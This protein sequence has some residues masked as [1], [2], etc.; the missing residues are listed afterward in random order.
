M[1]VHEIWLI[2]HGE[3][4]WSASGKHTGRTDVPL[5]VKGADQARAIGQALRGRAFALVLTSPLSRAL[6]TCCLA[7]YG[8]QTRIEPDLAEWDYGIFEGRTT[9]EI[10]QNVPAWSIWTSSVANGE[11]I[12]DVAR[13]ADRVIE[14]ASKVDGDIALFSHGHLLRILTASW[15]G[16]PPRDGRLFALDTAST[17]VLGHE[18][19]TRVIRTWNRGSE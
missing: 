14:I 16:L 6:D 11:S 13:R 19:E 7:G 15:L 3:T 5:T 18:R 9:A 10:R 17:S 8:E 2:R 4:E 1:S 12:E